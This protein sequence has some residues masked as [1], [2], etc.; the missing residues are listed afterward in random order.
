[1]L[2]LIWKKSIGRLER[3]N[4]ADEQMA[5]SL[6]ELEG[7]WEEDNDDSPYLEDVDESS[8]LLGG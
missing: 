3:K 5:E 1:M 7:K 4:A 8:R 2:T 6:F